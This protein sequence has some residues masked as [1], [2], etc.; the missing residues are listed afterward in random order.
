MI[1]SKLF[2]VIVIFSIINQVKCGII[3]DFLDKLLGNKDQNV[4]PKEKVYCSGLGDISSKD[5]DLITCQNKGSLTECQKCM[6]ETFKSKRGLSRMCVNEQLYPACHQK[7]EE[8]DNCHNRC[9]TPCFCSLSGTCRKPSV[10][11]EGTDPC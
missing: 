5:N 4:P 10:S 7:V 6:D 9:Q 8:L 1:L 3:S 11:G 2:L